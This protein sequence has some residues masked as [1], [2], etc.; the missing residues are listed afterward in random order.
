MFR[1][2][3]EPMQSV[4]SL[5]SIVKKRLD[6]QLGICRYSEQSPPLEGRGCERIGFHLGS[7]EHTSG[8][9]SPSVTA[10]RVPGMNPRPTVK[11]LAYRPIEFLRGT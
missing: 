11:T 10:A 3:N 1:H 5:I 7:E 6:E 8:D 4:S 2:H 9:K